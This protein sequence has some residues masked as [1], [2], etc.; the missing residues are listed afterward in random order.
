[1]LILS[2][3]GNLLLTAIVT[4]PLFVLGGVVIAKPEPSSSIPE[5]REFPVD[6]QTNPCQDFYAYACNQA[7]DSFALRPDRS[8]H[9]FAFNDS[10]E[11]L[12]AKKTAYLKGVATASRQGTSLST[13]SNTL[14]TVYNACMDPQ[15]AEKETKNR[16]ASLVKRMA[17]IKDHKA[18]ARFLGDERLAARTSFL[19]IGGI[20]N[21][22][23]P[24]DSD[25]YF[26]AN[27]M[28]L[29][30]RSYYDNPKL[31]LDY[32]MVLTQF[33]QTLGYK[34]SAKRATAVLNFETAFAKISPLPEEWREIIVKKS[35]ISRND[36]VL[37][38]PT[39]HL[40]DFLPMVPEA[41]VVRHLTPET[42]AWLNDR[43]SRE[44][45]ETLKSV[46]LFASLGSLLDDGYASFYNT[47]RNFNVTYLGAPKTRP[48]REERCTTQVMEMFTKELDAELLPT[49]FPDFPDEKFVSLAEQVRKAIII[50]IDKNQWLS[51]QG[52]AGARKK[53]EKATLQLVKPRNDN[54]WYFNPE[55]TYSQT[56]P[57]GNIETRALKLQERELR[58][59]KEKRDPTR[60]G[61][62]PLTVNAYYSAGDNKFVMPIGILQYPF[63]DPALP[64][65]VNLGAVGSVIG[66][67][68]GHGIDDQG[69]QFDAEGRLVPWMSEADL[70]NFKE[71]GQQLVKQF[72][73]IGHNGRLTLGE[74]I[75]DL[76]GITFAYNAAFPEGKGSDEM[77][78]AFFLQYARV[79]C[80]VMLPKTREALLKTDPHSLGVARVNQQLKNQPAFAKAFQ[81]RAQDAMV[82]PPKEVV[83]IW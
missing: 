48:V 29:P 28:T 15:S 37:K 59:L 18:F 3:F 44:D 9:T 30:E 11:R 54:E 71:R 5:R 4:F 19:E 51:E 66:H 23:R 14:A 31:R 67:E 21:Q 6:P 79:W 47:Y 42:F 12:L 49:L 62:G 80:Q 34:D 82:L 7:I 65:E 10:S 16:V 33:F 13:R 22:D 73:A 24:E 8:K 78:K 1:M 75:G 25:F 52:K 57:Q 35:A 2:K 81:C 72:D 43:L 53:M 17:A 27:A 55:A 20:A 69:A 58:E 76:T 83:K 32:T 36:L 61:M 60:W 68:L 46:Y 39:F 70:K 41:T 45:L 56:E 40:D 77:K 64:L 63:Y 38:Y 50:G 26:T 74:N